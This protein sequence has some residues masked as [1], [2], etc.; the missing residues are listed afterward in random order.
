MFKIVFQ[1]LKFVQYLVELRH[2]FAP[3]CLFGVSEILIL[4]YDTGSCTSAK[5]KKICFPYKQMFPIKLIYCFCPHH[6]G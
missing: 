3:M 1:S 6:I 4:Y 2:Y 5:I